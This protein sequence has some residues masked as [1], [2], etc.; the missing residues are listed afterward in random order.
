MSH[1]IHLGRNQGTAIWLLTDLF[2][3]KAIGAETDGAL[4]IA[5]VSA[6]PEMGPPPHVH[7]HSDECFYVLE[8]TWDFSLDGR[9]FSAGAGSFVYLPKGIVHTH[10]AGGGQSARAL[11]IQTPAGVE[12]FIEEAGKPATDPSR[13]P[14]PPEPS[15]LGPIVAI[16]KKHGIDVPAA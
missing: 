12:H 16:A 5:E 3:F 10:R 7:R 15:A 11:V 6:G 1:A 8:G 2:T 9:S 13:R 4:S 14:A